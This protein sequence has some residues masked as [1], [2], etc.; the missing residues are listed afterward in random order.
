[1]Y[2]IVPFLFILLFSCNSTNSTEGRYKAPYLIYSGNNHSVIINWQLDKSNK[3][4][5]K[6]SWGKTTE[7]EV[8]Q[9]NVKE[10]GNDHQYKYIIDDLDYSTKY[11]YR[12]ILEDDTI[13]GTFRTGPT[14]DE[15]HIKFLV[16]GDTRTNPQIHDSVAAQMVSEYM[17]NDSLQSILI[18]T[19][20]MV[21]NGDM[22]EYWSEQF[23]DTKYTNIQHILQNLLYVAAL[24]NHEKTGKLFAKYFPYP[25]YSKDR[26]YWSFDYGPAHFAILDQ[27]TDYNK[28]SK[29]YIWLEKDL[30]KSSKRWKFVV[31]HKPG[32][33]AG[34]HKN[35]KEVQEFIQPLCKKY[36]VSMILAGHNHYYAKAVVDGVYHITTGGGG[37][38]LYDIDV[39]QKNVEVAVKIHHFSKIE[40]DDNLLRFTAINYKGDVIDSFRIEKK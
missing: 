34:G 10:Y 3:N 9:A 31:L 22:E 30:S 32:W 18:S 40:I 29:Q 21:S 23:F 20:D 37:A 4:G 25:F 14:S 12:V 7:Y 28:E 8:G 17:A 38:P 15:K 13:A 24:G 27:E 33:T 5:Q 16:Y 26:F 1:M 2:K 19:G 11:F 36:D 6:L 39:N 35:N